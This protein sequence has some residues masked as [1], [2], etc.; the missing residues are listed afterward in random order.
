[1][2][3]QPGSEIGGH[4][5]GGTE[6]LE[7]LFHERRAGKV[8]A[9]RLDLARRQQLEHALG[10]PDL[11]T[12]VASNIQ[13]ETAAR[14]SIEAGKG[15]LYVIELGVFQDRRSVAGEIADAQIP[16]RT[17]GVKRIA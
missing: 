1:M 15:R 13:N 5:P 8:K 12:G 4:R 10:E 7:D 6:A 11:A 14:F 16:E 2:R 9:Q 3:L 17:Y